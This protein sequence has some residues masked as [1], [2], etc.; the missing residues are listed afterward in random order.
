MATK[1][2]TPTKSLITEKVL[3]DLGFKKVRVPSSVT[4]PD[5]PYYY[6]VFE[7]VRNSWTCLISND[8]EEARNKNWKVSFLQ[9][10]KLELTDK[11]KLKTLISAIKDMTIVKKRT[12]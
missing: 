3:V 12:Q 11:K 4:Y 6:Y 8:S 1:I 10:N 5:P 2:K 9:E 7:P